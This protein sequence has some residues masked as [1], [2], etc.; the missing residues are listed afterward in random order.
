MC[1]PVRID[2]ILDLVRQVWKRSPDLR[3]GPKAPR[4]STAE[5]GAVKLVSNGPG[6]PEV[7]AKS[8]IVAESPTAPWLGTSVV[9]P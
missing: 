1:D 6:C 9:A 5:S 3:L 8:R 7:S 2:Q 4:L